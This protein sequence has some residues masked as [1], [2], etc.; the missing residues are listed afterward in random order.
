[1]GF[2]FG[3]RLLLILMAALLAVIVGLA[4]GVLAH[5]DEARPPA[6]IVRAAAACGVALTLFLL[7]LCSL[8]LLS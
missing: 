4:A 6:C 8:G 7:T 3:I 1:M 5:L 2:S